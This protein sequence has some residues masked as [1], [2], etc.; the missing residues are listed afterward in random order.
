MA[1]L[2]LDHTESWV[3]GSSLLELGIQ[4]KPQ[5]SAF[6]KIFSVGGIYTILT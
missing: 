3:C 1:F 4:V 5:I 2:G 6:G